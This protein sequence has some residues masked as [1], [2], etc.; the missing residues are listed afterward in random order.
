[1]VVLL[2]AG[3]NFGRLPGLTL[4]PR[5]LQVLFCSGLG[6]ILE[7]LNVFFR[8]VGQ[9]FGSFLQFWFWLIP[10]STPSPSCPSRCSACWRSTC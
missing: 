1:M 5:L 4:I 6:M 9:F 2:N 7:V 3:I 8:N 10:S